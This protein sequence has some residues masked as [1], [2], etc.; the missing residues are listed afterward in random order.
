MISIFHRDKGKKGIK[1]IVPFLIP[2]KSVD[3][4]QILLWEL[5]S[6]TVY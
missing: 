1:R 6:I 2:L 5:Y 3:K 4:V